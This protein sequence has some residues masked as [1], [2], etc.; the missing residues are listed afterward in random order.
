MRLEQQ[1]FQ[2]A[3]VI[4]ATGHLLAPSSKHDYV[5]IDFWGALKSAD[6]IPHYNWGGWVK[7]SILE[8]ARRVQTDL[9]ANKPIVISGCHIF[10]Q[11]FF[12]DNMELGRLNLKQTELP[13]IKEFTQERMK[14]MI[15]KCVRGGTTDDMY[16]ISMP[17]TAESVCYVRSKKERSFW[18]GER[19]NEEEINENDKL[20]SSNL[21]YLNLLEDAWQYLYTHIHLYFM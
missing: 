14:L 16:T 3:F 4:F 20:A 10:L 1:C 8:C 19:I 9:E 17:R 13:R 18:R 7:K 12:L 11:V 21:Q 6:D 5:A 15:Q 2:I